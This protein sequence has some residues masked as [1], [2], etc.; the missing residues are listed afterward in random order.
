MPL[1]LANL[2]LLVT[3]LVWGTPIPLFDWLLQRWDPVML[4]WLRYTLALPVLF[5]VLLLLEGRSIRREGLKPPDVG[6]G[7]LFLL[8]GFGVGGFAVFFTLG[9]SFSDP[10]MAAVLSTASPICAVLV[11]FLCWRERIGGGLWLGILLTVAGA[12][13]ASVEIEGGFALRFGIGEA[14]ILLSLLCWAWYSASLPRWCPSASQLRATTV[15]LLPSALVMGVA[16]AGL[17]SL[18]LA[19]WRPVAPLPLDLPLLLWVAG[20]GVALGTLCWNLGVRRLG[21]VTAA[22]YLN[23][24]PV[25]AVLTALALGTVPRLEQLLG[26]G[27]VM[28]GVLFVQLSNLHRA[29][30]RARFE[31]QLAER[32][33]GD[34]AVIGTPALK[35]RESGLKPTR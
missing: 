19:A 33:A 29:R 32:E 13:L 34:Q 6:W 18:G 4:A 2:S 23:L 24:I 14:L 7:R 10:V 21:P 28:T 30:R 5:A 1:L 11:G 27:L 8:G 16:W 9:L 20:S 22:L 26:G 35:E 12:G 17:A 25:I 3:A 31:A 15:T